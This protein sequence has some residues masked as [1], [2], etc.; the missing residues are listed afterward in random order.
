MEEMKGMKASIVNISILGL[1]INTKKYLK[2]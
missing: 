2:K 1:E